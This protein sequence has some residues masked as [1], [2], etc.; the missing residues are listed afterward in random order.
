MNMPIVHD[1]EPEELLAM[2]RHCA[3]KLLLAYDQTL[4]DA[5]WEA[6]KKTADA[7]ASLLPLIHEPK[8][9]HTIH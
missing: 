6:S 8:E 9:L 4:Q 3:H 2:L 7:C 5:L 1:C